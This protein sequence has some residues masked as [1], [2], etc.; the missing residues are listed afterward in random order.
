MLL[1]EYKMI[2]GIKYCLGIQS[3]MFKEFQGKVLYGGILVYAM[4]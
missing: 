3:Y 2:I 4:T 1:C